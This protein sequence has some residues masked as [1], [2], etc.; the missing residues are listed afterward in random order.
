VTRVCKDWCDLCR[1]WG[2]VFLDAQFIRDINPWLA[3]MGISYYSRTPA[4]AP[5]RNWCGGGMGGNEL[6]SFCKI[7][8]MESYYQNQRLIRKQLDQGFRVEKSSIWNNE[9]DYDRSR[10]KKKEARGS[11][12]AGEQQK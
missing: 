2:L 7:L 5:E 10:M 12:S 3:L 4:L 9:T 11:K 6:Y 1:I 8:Q